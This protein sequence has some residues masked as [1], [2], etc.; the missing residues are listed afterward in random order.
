MKLRSLY[1]FPLAAGLT[2][3]ACKKDSTSSPAPAATKTD[4]L[5]AK[6]WKTTDIKIG[7]TSIFNT[8]LI[9]DCSKDD[10]LKFNADKSSIYDEGA[11][12]CVSTDPQTA[13][14]SWAFTTDETKLKMTDPD[15]G[16]IEATITTLNA[17]TLVLSDPNFMNSGSSGELTLTAQ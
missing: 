10:L 15:G 3:A 4:M 1:L 17:T 16:V 6:N 12:K 8:P 5:T 14:G 2:L 7:G 9:D 13:K 11:K